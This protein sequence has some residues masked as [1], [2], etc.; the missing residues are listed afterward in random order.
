MRTIASSPRSGREPW[1]AVPLVSISAQAKPLWATHARRPVGSVMMHPS[2]VCVAR[3]DAVPRLACSSSET[4]VTMRSPRRSLTAAA[5]TRQAASRGLHVERAAAVQAVALDALRDVRR[6]H[7][8]QVGVEHQRAAA[9][10]AL[11]RG[12]HA[13]AAG[14]G[15]VDLRGE[16]GVVQPALH[17]RGDLRL[18]SAAGDERGVDRVDRDQRGRQLGDLPR[19]VTERQAQLTL[20]SSALTRMFSTPGCVASSSQVPM[21][22]WIVPCSAPEPDATR[23]RV[24]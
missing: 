14:C 3:T 21:G 1:A 20:S 9:A 5:T 13:R 23:V 24:T 17:E 15:L 8:V 4:S 10:G 19:V 7:R 11:G 18:A 12:D 2:A 16:A 6:A 22:S